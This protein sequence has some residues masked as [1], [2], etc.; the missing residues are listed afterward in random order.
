M[1]KYLGRKMNQRVAVE[2]PLLL[3]IKI[4]KESYKIIQ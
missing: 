3:S 1:V 4:W 2:G